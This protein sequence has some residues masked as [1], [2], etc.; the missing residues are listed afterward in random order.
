GAHENALS[1]NRSVEDLEVA[2]RPAQAAREIEHNVRGLTRLHVLPAL[3]RVFASP[4]AAGG[5][6]ERGVDDD[7]AVGGRLGINDDLEGTVAD[8]GVVAVRGADR[9]QVAA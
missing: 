5:A 6:A 8:E 9:Q 7:V 4:D 1:A 2:V 3:A